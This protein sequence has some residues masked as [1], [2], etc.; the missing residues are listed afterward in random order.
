MGGTRPLAGLRWFYLVVSALTIVGSAS[1][2]WAI[3]L[4]C[5]ADF[6]QRVDTHLQQPELAQ[7]HWGILLQASDE[8][9]PLYARNADQLFVPASNVKLLTTAAALV[10]LGPDYQF[11]TP[12]YASG[13]GP[14]LR[15]LRLV[16]Q[17]DP[18][19]SEDQLRATAESLKAKGVNRIQTLILEDSSDP[20]Q[21]HPP[22][23]E[24][25]DLL[26][27][28][29]P[30][31]NR[32]ILNQNQVA[33]TLT[34]GQ[35]GEALNIRWSDPLAGAQFQVINRSR[36][37]LN[38][39]RPPEIKGIYGQGQLIIS[40]ELA[41]RAEAD[42]TYLAIPKP[43]DYFLATW[44]QILVEQG[45]QIEAERIESSPT[46]E[47][48][49][50]ILVITSP[51]LSTLIQTT[52]QESNNLYAETLR[53]QLARLWPQDQNLLAQPLQQLNI[54]ASDYSLRDGSG[55][56]RHN[57]ASPRLLTQVLQNLQASPWATVYKQSLPVAGQTGTLKSRF[58]NTDLAGNL[59]AKTGTLGGVVSLSGYL[60]RKDA[61]LLTFSILVNNARTPL[62]ELRQ[63]LDKILALAYQTGP[64]P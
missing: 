59:T 40:G 50:L 52:N 36:T 54:K 33:L 56:S 9:E 43:R 30:P 48:Q 26:Y 44:H 20:T 58:L 28:Y 31:I 38:P 63:A 8:Q 39:S 37:A 19:L 14:V 49:K 25:D 27:G 41:P 4:L 60:S 53:Q 10:A 35:P 5:P 51:P 15:Q 29:A 61:S 2:S 24:W 6:R 12:I 57:L 13:Q 32:A 11:Q 21:D 23:W 18:S 1:K 46:T 47:A 34:P 55:L 42:V 16:A 64:C 45:I 7:A 22:S 62:P 17:G 3:P